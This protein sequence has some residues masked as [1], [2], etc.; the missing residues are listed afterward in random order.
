MDHFLQ[1]P[2]FLVILE[3]LFF[4]VYLKNDGQIKWQIDTQKCLH[5]FYSLM[6]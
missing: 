2:A 5:L 6:F 3:M 4:L 1:V